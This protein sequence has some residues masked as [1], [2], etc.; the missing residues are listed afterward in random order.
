MA[1]LQSSTST[2]KLLLRSKTRTTSRSNA[3]KR[4]W[5]KAGCSPDVSQPPHRPTLRPFR[6]DA[7]NPTRLLIPVLQNPA[8]GVTAKMA[9]PRQKTTTP[10]I[11]I[12]IHDRREWGGTSSRCNHQNTM[13]PRITVSP[14]DGGVSCRILHATV[15][16]RAMPNVPK[17][18]VTEPIASRTRYEDSGE[19]APTAFSAL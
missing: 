12:S 8:R 9:T 19:A 6:G 5:R 11:T 7:A 15:C 14:I 1:M 4:R 3:E 18:T 13:A 2:R 17:F 16:G 10:A